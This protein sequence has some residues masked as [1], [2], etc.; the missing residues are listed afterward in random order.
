MGLCLQ[1]VIERYGY[2]AKLFQLD[3]CDSLRRDYIG[4]QRRCGRSRLRRTLEGYQRATSTELYILWS[5]LSRR[6]L[7]PTLATAHYSCPDNASGL[8]AKCELSGYVKL[9][10]LLEVFGRKFSVGVVRWPSAGNTG[11][12]TEGEVT[13]QNLW[14]RHVRHSVGTTWHNVWS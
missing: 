6:K 3:R 5:E 8:V 9:G 4:I 1:R 13:S 2:L 10:Q 12:Y 7:S 14:P 11:G